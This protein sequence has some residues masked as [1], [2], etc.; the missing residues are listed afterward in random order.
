MCLF[1]KIVNGL[2]AI[3]HARLYPA[4]LSSFSLFPLSDLPSG[5]D[6]QNVLNYSFFSAGHSP[7]EC[8][9]CGS[10]MFA[11]PENSVT[12]G[13]WSAPFAIQ[14][15]QTHQLMMFF[16]CFFFLLIILNTTN[17]GSEQAYY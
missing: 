5:P 4:Q 7:M 1:Y 16:C 3:P 15:V 12:V 10:C 9:A 11:N 2:V 8:P 6:F 13:S 17:T 14:P